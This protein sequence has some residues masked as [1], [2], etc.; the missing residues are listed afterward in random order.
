MQKLVLYGTL[1]LTF[2]I[3]LFVACSKDKFET[4]PTLTIKSFSP[5]PVPE[6]S[7]LVIEL[8]YTDKEGDIA[9]GDS[10]LFVRRYRINQ[11]KVAITLRDSF[12]MPLPDDV[13]KKTK[14]TIR[15]TFQYQADVVSAS[16]PGSG[17]DKAPDSLIYRFAVRDKAQHVSDTVE[18]GILVVER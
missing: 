1:T 7:P 2:A 10:A 5:N 3:V 17:T 8:E 12:W 11:K 15:L 13:P 4:K 16:D 14:G 6:N 18:S 9:S